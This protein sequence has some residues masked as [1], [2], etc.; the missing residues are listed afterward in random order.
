MASQLTESVGERVVTRHG[1]T[2]FFFAMSGAFLAIVLIGFAPTFYLHGVFFPVPTRPAY[3]YVH[4]FVMTA[5]FLVLF[6]QTGL[7]R[8]GHFQ[9]HRQLGVAGAFLGLGVVITGV[10]VA[11][12]VVPGLKGIPGFDFASDISVLGLGS[13]ETVARFISFVVW[14]NLATAVTFSV[15]LVSAILFRRQPETHKRLML[16]SSLAVLSPA[17]ARI[18][19]WPGLGGEAGPFSPTV[20][21]LLLAVIVVHDLAVTKRVR[22]IIWVGGGLVVFDYFA[23]KFI[24]AT[25]FGQT[26]VMGL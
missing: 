26:F 5:W 12:G 8:T 16:M 15:L 6:I 25:E 21:F 22:P 20:W 2:S 14:A 19:R 9:R 13:G 4:G 11:L 1:Y 7:I 17:I 18:S 24:A 3:V 10:T 23:A